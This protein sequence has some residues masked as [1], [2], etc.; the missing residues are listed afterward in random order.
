MI[1]LVLS[2]GSVNVLYIGFTDENLD[3]FRE[4]KPAV[5]EAHE[6][7]QLLR[8]TLPLVPDLIINVLPTIGEHFAYLREQGF[9]IPDDLE[10][11]TEAAKAT[12]PPGGQVLVH[13]STIED[14]DELLK[15][16]VPRAG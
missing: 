4:G 8:P 3:R 10:E 16:D 7:V 9:P 13:E 6:F 15:K 11:R 12:M 2:N 14:E 1:Q 5:L